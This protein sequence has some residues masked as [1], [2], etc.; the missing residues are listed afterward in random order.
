MR[1]S[2]HNKTEKFPWFTKPQGSNA[3][4]Q[5]N[6]QSVYSIKWNYI[7]LA[8]WVILPDCKWIKIKSTTG[9]SDNFHKYQKL[10]Y[11]QNDQLLFFGARAQVLP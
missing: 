7:D 4:S 6:F 8:G 9:W 10:D 2:K 3:L 11:L 5:F 1:D